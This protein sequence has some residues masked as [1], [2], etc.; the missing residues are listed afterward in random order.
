MIPGFRFVLGAAAGGT[1]L[2]SKGI[3]IRLLRASSYVVALAVRP[4]PLPVLIST[5]VVVF[6][7]GVAY[8]VGSLSSPQLMALLYYFISI[9]SIGIL[10][11]Y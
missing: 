8:R 9:M 11:N 5:A 6:Y 1:E 4:S 7:I 10:Y 2:S 3:S